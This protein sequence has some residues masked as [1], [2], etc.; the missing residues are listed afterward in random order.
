VGR[1]KESTRTLASLKFNVQVRRAAEL[2]IA[3]AQVW[4]ES[5]RPGLG[6]EFHLQISRILAVFSQTPRIYPVLRRNVRRALI[7]RFPYLLW[8]RV[9]GE[10][11]T[12]L[13]CTHARQN[14]EKTTRR[15]L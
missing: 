9:V 14:P 13:A 7:R 10:T 4:Y 12:V 11:V 8:Y 5:Q 15:F 1:R 2:D 3:E 6:L